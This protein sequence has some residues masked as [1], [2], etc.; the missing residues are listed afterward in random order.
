MY[1]IIGNVVD[2]QNRP[3]NGVNV[4]DGSKETITDGFGYYELK[5]DKKKINFKR[6]G[7]LQESFDLSKYKDGSKVNVDITL[8]TDT[9]STTLKPFEVVAQRTQVTEQKKGL[10]K[11]QMKNVG[12][13]MIGIALILTSLLVYK[14]VKKN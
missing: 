12:L 1:D 6:V 10:T 8:K 5:T 9:E 2:E 7:F 3:I 11:N 14:A 4:D 13:V